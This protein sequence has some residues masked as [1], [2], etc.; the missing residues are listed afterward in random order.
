M[1][2]STFPAWMKRRCRSCVSDG[3]KVRTRRFRER[4][5]V[6]EGD[7]MVMGRSGR[8]VEKRMVRCKGLELE[9]DAEVEDDEG[10]IFGSSSSSSCGWRCEDSA[11]LLNMDEVCN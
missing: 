5:V 9:V 3:R 11:M 2:G 1:S 4:M 8:E 7:E 6:V 10:P